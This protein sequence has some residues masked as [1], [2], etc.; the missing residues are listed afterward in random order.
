MKNLFTP[1]RAGWLL[2]GAAFLSFAAPALAQS[3]ADELIVTGHYG[4]VPDNVQS[5]S[6]TVS[7]ADL[8]LSSAAGRSELRHRVRLT[9]RYLCEKLGESDSA[10]GITPTCRDAASKDAM[11][12]VG[13]LEAHASPRGTTW[14]AGPAW[15]PP[16]PEAWI[17]RYP[18]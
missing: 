3:D 14:V 17:S 12:R 4:R 2:A 9:S 13:T 15:H 16:Y 18:D 7:Y 1:S 10:N 5:L 8:D 6:Q 11:N